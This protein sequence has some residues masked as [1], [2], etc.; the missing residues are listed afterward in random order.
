MQSSRAV[1]YWR[2]VELMVRSE[3]QRVDVVEGT[4]D[5]LD[6]CHVEIVPVWLFVCT[7]IEDRPNQIVLRWVNFQSATTAY[8]LAA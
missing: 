5:G 3:F 6:M 7:L 1:A 2:S 8:A 4:E